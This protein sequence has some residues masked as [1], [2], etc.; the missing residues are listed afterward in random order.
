[1]GPALTG[2]AQLD[3]FLKDLRAFEPDGELSGAPLRTRPQQGG[4]IVLPGLGIGAERAGV[5]VADHDDE[6]WPQDREQGSQAWPPA[7]AGRNIAT[8]NGAERA[9]NI[10][11][12]GFIE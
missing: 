8:T 5:V 4:P 9:A 3:G 11:D 2:T 10:A 7:T 1:M 6:T 12:I